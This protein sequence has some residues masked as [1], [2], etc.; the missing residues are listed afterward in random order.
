MNSFR[1]INFKKALDPN[2]TSYD[3]IRSWQ[4]RW[5]IPFSTGGERAEKYP[6]QQYLEIGLGVLR[7]SPKVFW[8]LTVTEF[9]SA[10]N[11]YNLNQNL[12]LPRNELLHFWIHVYHSYKENRI[13][14]LDHYQIQF[15]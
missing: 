15:Q 13:D 5:R 14:L 1:D 3:C 8:D 11:G 7:F 6:I 10:L 12:L 9:M 2:F 4:E